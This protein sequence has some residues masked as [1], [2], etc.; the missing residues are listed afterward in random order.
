MGL[1]FAEGLQICVLLEFG[2]LGLCIVQILL[3]VGYFWWVVGCSVFFFDSLVMLG[4]ICVVC[5]GFVFDSGFVVGCLG[6]LVLVCLLL[7][8]VWFI[9]VF[10]C[11]L[12]FLEWF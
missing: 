10:G 5:F 9:V 6:V 2:F 12:I 11:G 1:D 3:V 4:F 7:G 8:F